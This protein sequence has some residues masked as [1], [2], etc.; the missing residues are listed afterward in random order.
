MPEKYTYIL[1]DLMCMLF[2][3]ACSFHSK[4]NFHKQWRNFVA[5]CLMASFFFLVW[6][7]LFTKAGIW[8]FNSRYTLG[9]DLSHL[10]IEEYL[11]F[12]C[13]PYACVFTYFCISIFWDLSRYNKTATGATWVFILFLAITV[14]F[15]LHQLYTS[16][17]FSLLAIFLLFVVL[18]KRTFLPSFYVSFLVI[19]IPFFISNGILTGTGLSEPVV[20]YNDRYNTGMR[21]LTIP[22]EDFF[23]GMLLMLI[24]IT[25]FD[26]LASRNK[27]TLLKKHT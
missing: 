10:P 19:L 7:I 5:P 20:R 24:N 16:V 14:A 6:D 23:Y 13:I 21:I 8:G 22:V 11:F 4:I 18:S 25:G 12:I 17:T 26:Y 2:P 3:F 15:Y 9:I 27:R 1:V